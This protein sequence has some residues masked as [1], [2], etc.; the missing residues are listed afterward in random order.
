[1]K[2]Y[3][4]NGYL[5]FENIYFKSKTMCLIVGARGIGKT[6]GMLK[7]A[8][9]NNISFAYMRRTQTQLDLLKSTDPKLNPFI[10][11]NNDT[12]YNLSFKKLN[13]QVYGIYNDQEENARGFGIAL[14]TFGNMRSFGAGVDLL[15]FDEFIADANERPLKREAESF[16]NVIESINRNRELKGEKPVKIMCLANSNDVGTPILMSLNLVTRAIRMQEK[17]IEEYNTRDLTLLLPFKS[18]IAENKKDTFLYRLTE[19]TAFHDMAVSNTF[20]YNDLSNIE[21]KDIKEY[22]IVCNVAE[23]FIYKHK[24]NRTYYVTHFS[25]GTTKHVYRSDEMDTR[26][27]SKDYYYLW[28]AHLKNRVKFESYS[29]KVLFEKYFNI[30]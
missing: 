10:A 20:S 4:K 5:N 13:K 29:D 1:M 18:P 25:T 14:S 8:L 22:K 6:Y 21:S 17:Q 15:I 9:D 12:N 27:F 23:I 7:F 24:S 30:R 11:L 26:R 28:L 2:L 19:N 3:D 16:F